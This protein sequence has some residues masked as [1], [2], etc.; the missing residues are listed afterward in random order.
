MQYVPSI[1]EFQTLLKGTRR[2]IHIGVPLI[3]ADDPTLKLLY[4][5]K[6][7][8][9]SWKQYLTLLLMLHDF[10]SF[11]I[12]TTA[13]VTSLEAQALSILW[14]SNDIRELNTIKK[15]DVLGRAIMLSE[16][17]YVVVYT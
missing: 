14:D 10:V 9:F 17:T 11:L 6:T 13:L 12:V 4:P 2:I 3:R 8:L 16:N 1:V 5:A 15:M 7:A